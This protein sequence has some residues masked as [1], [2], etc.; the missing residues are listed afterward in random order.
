ML[1][2]AGTAGTAGTASWDVNMCGAD[3]FVKPLVHI[4]TPHEGEEGKREGGGERG[5][6]AHFKRF[7]L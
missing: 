3:F 1:A 4:R 7:S 5:E 2:T 6:Q